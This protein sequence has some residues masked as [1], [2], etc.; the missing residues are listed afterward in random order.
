MNTAPHG[1]PAVL[2]VLT[3]VLEKLHTHA[4]HHGAV[5]QMRTSIAFLAQPKSMR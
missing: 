3:A 1:K 5:K 4:P 2:L